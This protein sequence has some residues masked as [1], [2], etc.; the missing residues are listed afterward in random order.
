MN[1]EKV[2]QTVYISTATKKFNEATDI[3]GILKVA[4]VFNKTQNI[5]GMLVYKA[6]IFLQLL[7]GPEKEVESLMSK[8]SKDERHSNVK[9]LLKQKDNPRLFGDWTMGYR[10]LQEVELDEINKFLDWNK[11]F[12]VS[13]VITNENILKLLKVFRYKV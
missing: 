3:D 2:F 13:A 11:M 9:I 5:T 6:G 7:E 10:K 1:Q 4:H 8:I 12:E